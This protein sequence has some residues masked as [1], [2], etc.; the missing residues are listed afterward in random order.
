[1]YALKLR[2]GTSKAYRPGELNPITIKVRQRTFLAVYDPARTLL[3][4]IIPATD[5]LVIRIA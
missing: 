1:M 2:L 3:Y 5:R 4:D